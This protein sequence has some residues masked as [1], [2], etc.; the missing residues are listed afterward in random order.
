MLRFSLD[1]LRNWTVFIYRVL[2]AKQLGLLFNRGLANTGLDT[3]VVVHHSPR[4]VA[5]F[6]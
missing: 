1:I 6:D 3:V 2:R 5:A 4:H